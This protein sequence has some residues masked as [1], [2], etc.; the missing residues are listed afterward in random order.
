[1]IATKSV[2]AIISARG[3]SK[4]IL[5]KNIRMLAGRPLIAW[6]ISEAKKSK[7]VDR[8]VISSEDLE[9][10]A[11]AREWGCEAPFIRP[12]EFARD[13]SSGIDPV[14]HGITT[15][16][17]K[18]DYVV[19]LQPTSPLRTVED[20]DGCIES[21]EIQNSP[22]CVSVTEPE[23][24]PYWMFKVESTGQM[25]PFLEIN[26]LPDCRQNLPKAYT[27]NGAVYV[28]RTH[29]LL[30]EKKFLTKETTAYIM[31]RHRSLDIDTELDLMVCEMLLSQLKNSRSNHHPEERP[32]GQF[33]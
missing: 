27:L 24:N 22:C 6:T 21:C 12:V 29:W 30:R 20:I 11:T 5:R 9:I 4:G 13:D 26:E 23:K 17:E 15:L 8:L 7:Y 32:R 14:L 33:Y 2:L 3:G 10:I 19:L 31:P 28:A 18:Y 1:M 16:P 25:I